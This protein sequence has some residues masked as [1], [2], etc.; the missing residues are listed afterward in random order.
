MSKKITLK[1]EQVDTQIAAHIS[2][3]VGFVKAKYLIDLIDIADLDA[4]PRSSKVGNV[5]DDIIESIQNTKEIFP[6]KTK[7]IL[8][9]TSTPPVERDRKRYEIEFENSGIEGILDGGH[10][11]LALALYILKEATDDHKDIKKIKLWSDLKPVWEK[12]KKEI[13]AIKSDIDVLVPVEILSPKTE[14]MNDTEAYLQSI[15]DICEARNNNVQLVIDTKANQAGHFETIKNIIDPTI[16]PDVVWKTNDPGR[17]P[18]RDII[19]L[20]WISLDLIELPNGT[21]KLSPV[22]LYSQKQRLMQSFTKLMEDEGV[23]NKVN[24]KYELKHTSISSALSIL[25]ILPKLYDTIFEMLPDTYNKVCGGKFGRI[26]AVEK[27]KRCSPKTP[28]YGKVVEQ[29][30]PEG[31]VTPLFYALTALLEVKDNKVSWKTDPE[32]FLQQNF[33]YI[34]PQ[35]KTIMEAFN[36]DPQ[37]VGKNSGAYEIAK[38]QFEMCLF[39]EQQVA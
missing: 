14:D 13:E 18:A 15:L 35:Y 3:L 39:K 24:G 31:F 32:K 37:K 26:K 17:I 25:N 19:A 28:F 8:L 16:K 34:L 38:Q 29:E 1:F 20:S 11:T 5:T 7:G 4:N 30:V 36:F 33:S 6:F 12:Y 23:S 10:N 2:R 21:P 27:K 9:A 22:N